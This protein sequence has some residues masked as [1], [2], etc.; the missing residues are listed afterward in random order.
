MNKILKYSAVS[1][2]LA[3]L[4]PVVAH[5][6]TDSYETTADSAP[7]EA[8]TG[9]ALAVFFVVWAFFAI[10]GLV[11]FVFWIIMLIDV[12][13][14]T[15]WKQESDKTLWIVLVILLGWI[16][17]AVYYFAVKRELDAKKPA[18]K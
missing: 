8:A 15:N 7:I 12:F 2:A 3:S 14:R 11:L 10:A 16:G 1:G 18:V 9:G 13:K 6:A 4:L 17:A 5:A